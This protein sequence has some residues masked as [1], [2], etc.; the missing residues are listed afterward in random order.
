M[1]QATESNHILSAWLSSDDCLPWLHDQALAILARAGELGLPDQLWPHE[2]PAEM[3]A[4]QLQ[5]AREE[6]AHDFWLYLR[7]VLQGRG[8][9]LPPELGP[10]G[11][12]PA[13][14]LAAYFRRGFLMRLRSLSRR[15]GT[16]LYHYL[17][18]RLRETVTQAPGFHHRALRWGVSYSLEPE[19]QSL[20]KLEGLIDTSY[21]QWAPP[22]ALVTEKDF[23]RC[24]V[25]DLGGL[26][27]LFWRE[28]TSRIGRP[29][30][31]PC[32]ELL[33]YLAAHYQCLQPGAEPLPADPASHRAYAAQARLGGL[34]V[35]ANQVMAPW[36]PARR[37]VFQ[38]S[39]DPGDL[40]LQEVAQ[41]SGLSSPSHAKYH[42]DRACED[43][44]KFC[45]TWPGAVPPS[46]E[47]GFWSEFLECVGLAC[48]NSIHGR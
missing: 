39:L 36:S 11:P 10:P 17:Y 20:S 33:A 24:R 18:R 6:V 46:T 4:S 27:E 16:S 26:A 21:K 45:E 41:R 48:K 37:Q 5:S 38:L 9:A 7:G 19:G 29:C 28:A 13:G 42:L 8:G 35:L 30:H 43:I 15:K 44:A 12:P 40:T 25:E 3:P 47:R 23:L 22:T 2:R 31:L 34:E 14:P 32:R 1:S